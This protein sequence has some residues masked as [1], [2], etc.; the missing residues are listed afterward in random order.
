MIL[1]PIQF[2]LI[3]YHLICGWTFALFY[4]FEHT[5]IYKCHSKKIKY[6]IEF[7]LIN[8]MFIF[9][10]KGL[11]TLNY[12]LTQMYCIAIFIIGFFIY[13]YLYFNTMNFIVVKFTSII[14][15]F[16]KA[17]MLVFIRISSIIG[18]RHN[19]WRDSI[20]KQKNTN[21]KKKNKKST[22]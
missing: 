13:Y 16:I 15:I 6:T 5:I 4:H 20:E 1:L 18:V 21:K 11:F 14:T 9:Y 19:K 3:I 22:S 2:K 8:I 17:I 7:I 12:G 10:Y